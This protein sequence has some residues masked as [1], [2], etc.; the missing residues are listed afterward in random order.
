MNLDLNVMAQ[1]F[2]FVGKRH[3]REGV[4]CTM[5]INGLDL[6]LHLSTPKLAL[7]TQAL[8]SP[9]TSIPL[10]GAEGTSRGKL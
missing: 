9:G 10:H 3:W 7:Q 6:N 2:L 8:K 5:T 1:S 4:I